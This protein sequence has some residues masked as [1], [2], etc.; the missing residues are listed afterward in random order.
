MSRKVLNIGDD[1]KITLCLTRHCV[2]R[3]LT[4]QVPQ[5][6]PDLQKPNHG[7]KASST[8]TL[9]SSSLFPRWRLAFSLSVTSRTM[10]KS[11][12]FAAT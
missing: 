6:F 3:P 8:C 5:Y 1:F 7:D 9:A 10:A 4:E 12:R 2:Q 11:I